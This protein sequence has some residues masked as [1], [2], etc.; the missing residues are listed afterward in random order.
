MNVL[1]LFI[2]GCLAGPAAAN[3]TSCMNDKNILIVGCGL[4]GLATAISLTT[5][6]DDVQITIVENRSNLDSRGA[7][8][9]LQVSGQKAL[10]EIAGV[11]DGTD[12]DMLETLKDKGM[13]SPSSGQLII[14]WWAVRDALLKEVK[15][16]E[17]RIKIHLGV[18]IDDLIEQEDGSYVAAFKESELEI[19]AD[20]IIGADGVHS[21]VRQNI[22]SLPK[23]TPSGAY[24]WRGSVD[25]NK[26]VDEKVNQLQQLPM[27]KF[28]QIGG[29]LVLGVFNFH[30]K[31]PGKIAWVF[32]AQ[33]DKFVG[34]MN[35][36]WGTTTPEELIQAY[37]D[38]LDGDCDEELKEKCDLAK[39]LFGNTHLPS[40]LTWSSELGFVDLTPENIS[41]G[42]RG[43]ITLIGDAAHAVRPTS[44]LG[45]SLAFEDAALLARYLARSDTRDSASIEEQLRAFEKIRLPRC[46]SIS[47]DQNIR[48]ELRYKVGD[49]G[50]PA[51]DP[52]YKKWIMDGIDATP[53]PPVS[54]IDVYAG[55]LSE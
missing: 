28:L 15:A 50:V 22:L 32:S 18:S 41:W 6:I 12:C 35:I 44:G 46:K 9:G 14:P 19:N 55:L 1:K 21:Y 54:E 52:A 42:G 3:L 30:S 48:A 33:T 4:S 16:R 40:D 10:N 29:G 25:T 31:L 47:N 8:L 36:D 51:W 49:R 53:E 24:V 7:T 26:S 45:G 13:L 37:M 23:A 2:V 39:L 38:S 11:T 27:G 5:H 34:N 20:V 43:R 17:D